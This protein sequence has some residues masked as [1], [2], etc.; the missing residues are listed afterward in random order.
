MKN[1][2]IADD[3]TIVRLGVAHIISTLPVP[4]KCIEAETFDRVIALLDI[5]IFD[6]LILDINIPGGNNLQMIDAV[7][8]RQP[9]IKIL[10][11]SGYDEQ[12]FAINYMQAG[13]DGYLMK[14]TPED[15]IR[16]AILTVMNREKYMSANTRQQMLDMLG[17][18]REQV[19][20][21]LSSLS[22][23]EVE[24][25]NLMTK[26]V[27]MATIAKMLHLQ[28][29]TVSTY[30]TRIFEKLGITNIVELLEKVKMY[31]AVV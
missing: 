20:N 5:H 26:G 22:A 27:P 19:V 13:A 3:H 15:E 7:K 1:I 11:F 17:S 4:A 21:P 29:T 14:Y 12:L 16:H 30:K 10:I 31:S 18:Q 2:L 8:L 6:V 9:Q 23:R 28:I 25:M 24:V